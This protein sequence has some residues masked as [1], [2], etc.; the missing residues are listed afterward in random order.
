[1][2]RQSTQVVECAVA[3]TEIIDGQHHAERAQVGE[4]LDRVGGVFDQHAFGELEL[5]RS[6]RQSEF[7]QHAADDL[8]QIVAEELAIRHIDR[9]ADD[10]KPG[11]TPRAHLSTGLAQYPGADAHD[12]TG[13]LGVADEVVRTHFSQLL[14]FPAD[15]CFGSDD[16]A[17]PQVD[18]RLVD[19]ME[20]IIVGGATQVRLHAQP[21]LLRLRQRRRERLPAVAD[22]SLAVVHRG[23]G[24]LDQHLRLVAVVRRSRDADTRGDG[25]FLVLETEAVA[26]CIQ[27]HVG[28]ALGALR[29][30]AEV[31]DHQ[32]LIA[33]ESRDQPFSAHCM[34]DPSRGR[35]QQFVAG[36]VTE[37]VVD[38]LE[39]VQVDVQHR[40][41]R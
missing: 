37:H 23:V 9:N 35:D 4:D 31:A 18:L 10:S 14:I 1:M 39:A 25:E 20:L 24:V 16:A 22:A 13:D 2:D 32:E 12:V 7:L 11:L 5:E 27:D 15:Q 21:L 40:N 19:Q 33:A 6:P 30:V 38:H 3:F 34:A 8:G 29:V 28:D 36:A 41:P 26:E 17:V